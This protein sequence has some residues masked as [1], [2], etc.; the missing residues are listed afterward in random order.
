MSVRKIKCE[1]L[2]LA[3][4]LESESVSETEKTT[5]LLQA[6]GLLKEGLAIKKEMLR[7]RKN[8]KRLH[9]IEE[10]EEELAFL[11]GLAA[12]NRRYPGTIAFKWAE[13]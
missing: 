3:D 2:R 13:Q 11:E 1:V 7:S 4:L 8:P 12:L 10:V 6:I 5:I 9:R